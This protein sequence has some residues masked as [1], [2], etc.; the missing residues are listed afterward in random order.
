MDANYDNNNTANHG[1]YNIYE[2]VILLLGSI[3]NILLI[4]I[5]TY[6]GIIFL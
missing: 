6:F 5:N 3:S 1:Y 4:R 2:E